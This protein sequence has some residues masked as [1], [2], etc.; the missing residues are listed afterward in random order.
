[1]VAQVTPGSAAEQAG[2]R[3][4]DVIIALNGRAVADAG[5]LRN[6]I[7]LL[8]V[9]TAVDL[10]LLRHGNQLTLRA[11]IADPLGRQCLCRNS[12]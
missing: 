12:K 10:G 2:V 7:G 3:S 5:D 1:M 8:R 6:A 9:G 4:G 11:V